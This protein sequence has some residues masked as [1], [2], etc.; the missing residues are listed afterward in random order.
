VP[1]IYQSL[2]QSSLGGG[3]HRNYEAIVLEG[4]TLKHWYR[5]NE[6]GGEWKRAQT[7]V[8]AGAAFA[9]AMIQSSLGNSN[10][11]VL[12]PCIEP[13]GNVALLH[14][15]RDNANPATPWQQSDLRVTEPDRK[16]VGPASLIE[17]DIDSGGVRNFDV[18]VPVVG[19][20]GKVELRH[21]FRHNADTSEPWQKAQQPVINSDDHEVLGAG[22]L[23]QST[24]RRGQ[25]GN[26]EVVGW[27]RLPDGREVLQHYWR[28]NDNFDEPWQ[29][30]L[31]ITDSARGPG[32][33]IQSELGAG[34]V[35]N[36][37]VVAPVAGLGGGTQLQY[38]FHDNSDVAN[39]WQRGRVISEVVSPLG[40]GCLMQSSY[41]G[42][43]HTSFEV[44]VEECSQS[45]TSYWRTNQDETMRWHR[46]TAVYREPAFPPG[47]E[48][49]QTERLCQVTGQVDRSVP[50]G[51]PLH[52]KY[53]R[54][55]FNAAAC[56]AVHIEGSDLG[57]SFVHDGKTYFLFGDTRRTGEPTDPYPDLD[58]IAYS[59]D[60]Q[61]Q[62]GLNLTFLPSP[63]YCAGIQH[64]GFNVPCEGFSYAGLM[65]VFFTTDSKS[66]T[67]DY[68]ADPDRFLTS[69]GST[70]LATSQDNGKTFS[71]LITW[72]DDKFIKSP[73]NAPNC[74]THRRVH[75]TGVQA[76]MC[77]GCGA[78]VATGAAPPIWLLSTWSDCGACFGPTRKDTG[79]SSSSCGGRTR[80]SSTSPA[81][82]SIRI[83]HRLST[84]PA[85]CSAA[86]RLAN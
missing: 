45:L 30:G 9:G 13:D 12:V 66:F 50:P 34:E 32:I 1:R 61:I 70:V 83:G 44:L 22:C 39:P 26:F 33:I 49:K 47:R 72:S 82:S 65:V 64:G 15:W 11:E 53:S 69:M 41:P 17:S 19:D 76:R 67:T 57:S 7:I 29:L 85:P 20:S 3:G 14:F 80:Q 48:I 31:V 37:E 5:D 18:V 81:T 23:I 40:C 8:P 46:A 59:T 63:P 4:D 24:F 74:P 56:K 68:L 42:A 51:Q 35:K 38:F 25:H 52:Q 2:I 28:Y 71:P 43:G 58:A 84:R 6:A 73:S 86:A 16:V 27:V 21:Y 62:G 60:S 54:P 36:F 75:S 55:A 10:F 78:L 77:S 79:S